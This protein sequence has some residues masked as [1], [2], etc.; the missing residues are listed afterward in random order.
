MH[1]TINLK[2][3]AVAAHKQMTLRSIGS[4]LVYAPPPPTF[5]FSLS[6]PFFLL[7]FLYPLC[8]CRFNFSPC[9]CFFI[10]CSSLP[11]STYFLLHVPTGRCCHTADPS[12]GPFQGP[13]TSCHC[14]PSRHNA[15]LSLI[16]L[17]SAILPVHFVHTL[18]ALRL[19]RF[20][21]YRATNHKATSFPGSRMEWQK[22]EGKRRSSKTYGS[23]MQKQNVRKKK[24][25]S[26]TLIC[27]LLL[28]QADISASLLTRNFDSLS[29]HFLFSFWT[30]DHRAASSFCIVSRIHSPS[31]SKTNCGD[32]VVHLVSYKS[33]V[34]ASAAT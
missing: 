28:A 26:H 18:T 21:R 30:T 22:F 9:S 11:F 8:F 4:Y 3:V 13:V 31:K 33:M 20:S 23:T 15:I 32:C 25:R 19:V 5:S 24:V 16:G 17:S 12:S 6:V 10:P 2:C 29:P 7:V 1:G 34:S 14:Y 27:N